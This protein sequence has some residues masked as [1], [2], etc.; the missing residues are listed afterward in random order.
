MNYAR[1]RDANEAGIIEALE[2][3]GAFVQKLGD[4]GVPDLLVSYGNVLTLLE[5]KLP[6]GPKGGKHHLGR[7]GA[8]ADLTAAQVKWFAKW[9]GKPARVVRSAEEALAAIGAEFASIG[10]RP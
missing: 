6:L 5:V 8:V 9:R 3:A 7:A 4:T 2:A 10:V 1:Q